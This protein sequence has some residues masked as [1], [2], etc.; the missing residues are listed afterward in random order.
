MLS[1]GAAHDDVLDVLYVIYNL[2]FGRI[3]GEDVT[4]WLTGKLA[5]DLF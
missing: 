5:C 1:M 2:K 4:F 3:V